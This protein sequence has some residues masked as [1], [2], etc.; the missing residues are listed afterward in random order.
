MPPIGGGNFQEQSDMMNQFDNMNMNNN[1]QN[2]EAN[3]SNLDVFGRGDP[4]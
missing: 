3:T 2:E 4:V 1:F